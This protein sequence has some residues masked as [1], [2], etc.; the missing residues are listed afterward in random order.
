MATKSIAPM[1]KR[2]DDEHTYVVE[3]SYFYHTEAQAKNSMQKDAVKWLLNTSWKEL[4]S[5]AYWYGRVER[6]T[7]TMY[8]NLVG[9]F[10][11]YRYRDNG[12]DTIDCIY[13]GK[14]KSMPT[15]KAK[16]ILKN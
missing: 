15:A 14:S 9:T 7:K 11:A 4:D 8:G 6:H 5:G 3:G 13:N 10:R 12:I 16:L 2:W 1:V